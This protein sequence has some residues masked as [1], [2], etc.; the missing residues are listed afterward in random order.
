MCSREFMKTDSNNFVFSLG[1]ICTDTR[2]QKSGIHPLS[3][4]DMHAKI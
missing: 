1:L 3:D 4:H 2:A